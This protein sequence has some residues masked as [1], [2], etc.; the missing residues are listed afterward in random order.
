MSAE[1]ELRR[2]LAERIL[3]LDGAMGT[4]IQ[5]RRLT[6][7]DFRGARFADH[8]K[9]L[10][11]ASDL[12]VLTKPAVIEEIHREYLEAGADL[13][14]TCTFNANGISM[15]DYGLVPLV[16]EMNVAAAAAAR[17]AVD[18][19]LRAHPGRTAF[20]AGSIGPTNR[21]ASLA[22][23]VANPRRRDTT[24]DDFVRA[25]REQ[26]RGLLDGGV[27]LLLVETVFDTLVAKASLF[28]IEELFAERGARVP[29]I[30]SV[31][32][33]DRSGRTLSGQTVEAFWNAVSHVPLLAVGINCALGAKEMRPYV[34]ELSAIAPVFLS[35]Y[36]NAGLPNAFGGFDETPTSMAADLRRFAEAGWVNVVGGCCGTTPDHIRAIAAAVA[37]L[38]PRRLPAPPRTLRL[39][40]LEAFAI[41]PDSNFTLIGERT[42]VTGSPRFAKLVAAG[43][44]DGALAVARQQVDGGANLLD[45]NMDEGMLDAPAAM[46]EFLNLLSAEPDIA[47]LPVMIDSSK[48]EVLEAGLKCLQG[49]AVVNSISLKEGEAAFLDHARRIR[50]YGAAVVVMAFDEE[51]QAVT[52]DRKLAIAGRAY[53]L[54]TER[55]GFPPEDLIFDPNVLTVGTG[56]EEHAGYGVAF[57]EAVRRIK[58]EL[59]HARTSGGISNV[60]FSFR[61]NNAVREAMHAAFLYH[62]IRAGLDMGIVNAGQLAVYEEVPED[63]LERVEDV[64]LDRR[65]DA[66]ERLVAFA[67]TVAR[68]ERAAARVDAWRSLPV[69]ER[70]THALVHGIVEHVEA[71]TEEARRKYGRPLAVIEGPLMAGMN[72]VGDLFGSGKMFLPQVVKSARVMKRAVAYLQPFLEAE[73]AG[74]AARAQG[75]VLLA[76]VKGDVHDIGK[77]IVSVVLACNNYAVVDLG[78]M[79]P[80]DRILAAILREK[81]DGVGLSGLITPSRDERVHVAREMAGAGLDLPLL[82]GGAT[83][84]PLHTA[85]K[86]APAY[87]GPVV[88]VLDASRAA[89]V[90]SNL[91]SDEQKDPFTAGNRGQ[92]A[93]LRKGH[94]EKSA[95]P[96]LPLAEARARGPRFDWAAADLPAPSFTGVRVI[97]DEPLAGLVPYVDWSPFFHAWELRGRYPQILD[98]PA[99]GAKA[100]ELFDDARRLLDEIES[101]RLLLARGVWGF[102]PA[103]AVGDDVELF[104]DETRSHLLA[105]LP[106]LR[107]QAPRTD[108]LP[109]LSLAD[110]V[111]PRSSGRADHLG[112][113]AVTAGHGADELAARHAAAHD[114]YA[115]I[116]SKA[117]AD[118]LVEAFAEKLH[119]EARTAWGYGKDESLST[120]DLLRER[121][122]GIRPAAGYPACP[123]HSEK[124]T[125]FAILSATEKAGISLTES[126][127]M[128]PAASVSGLY[129]SHPEA[130]YFAVGRLGKDQVEE[131]ARRKGIPLA[132]AERWLA[133]N[134][135]YEP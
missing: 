5:A 109:Q 85:V 64:L 55:A 73:T 113:F 121:Y 120:E 53:R 56:I 39:S 51:G 47:K 67:A 60:S 12:L 119:R 106:M 17:R 58:A 76:T 122:R 123:D 34:E 22:I 125:L 135:G 124:R 75:R 83:T 107:Q 59:P 70:L 78:V 32:I 90:V 37:G 33:T 42:N 3:V 66:T 103:N 128:H 118:R 92:Q 110:F 57:L 40:G 94:E 1:G 20:V 2:L 21:T 11:G 44:Y 71:D 130:R 29:V 50:R 61:G 80:A 49:K 6:D 131:Y 108:G 134:L 84:S 81:P 116:M 23:D 132:E 93:A 133:P 25:Y 38:P 101:K 87:S 36:P 14:E 104:T 4:R 79:V 100:R 43:D 45:V 8:P 114:D 69:E 63:L 48:W 89:G 54:L 7:A 68:G 112:A 65:P 13:V 105:T 24:F 86:I 41:R 16:H 98:D 15:A 72:V 18:G 28:A 102:F 46:T 99:V 97:E 62:A 96:L 19:F 77:N 74:G 26:V 129:L 117:L 91:L 52:A 10:K 95:K 115:A 31:T 88:H 126:F 35:A 111:A 27:D 30:L 127:A 9:E 82:I